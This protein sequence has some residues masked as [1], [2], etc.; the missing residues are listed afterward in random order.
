MVF[1]PQVSGCPGHPDY[2][3]GVCTRDPEL[4]SV[5]AGTC[6]GMFRGPLGVSF[7]ERCEVR[8]PPPAVS[9]WF[10][11]EW[12][13]MSPAGLLGCGYQGGVA[14]LPTWNFE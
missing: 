9:K 12:N 6:G 5:T 10:R 11:V 7:R 4:R 8:N 13:I 14:T 1:D 3:H 2:L